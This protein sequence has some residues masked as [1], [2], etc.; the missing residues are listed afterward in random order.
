[1]APSGD[2]TVPP[3]ISQRANEET[4]ELSFAEAA[5]VRD[6]ADTLPINSGFHAWRKFQT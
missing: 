4:K 5:Q 3:E 6:L 1:M 2:H